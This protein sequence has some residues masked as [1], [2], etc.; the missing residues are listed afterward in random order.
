[1]VVVPG[2]LLCGLRLGD[3]VRQIYGAQNNRLNFNECDVN[4]NEDEFSQQN[5]YVQGNESV[6]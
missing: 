2:Q 6:H 4:E 5:H 1:L 3:S